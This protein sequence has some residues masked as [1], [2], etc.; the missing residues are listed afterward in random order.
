MPLADSAWGLRVA[1]EGL[2]SFW[3][4]KMAIYTLSVHRGGGDEYVSIKVDVVLA[5]RW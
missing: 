3:A 1:L 4:S 5:E 2:Y